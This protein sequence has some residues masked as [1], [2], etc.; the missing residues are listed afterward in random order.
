MFNQK[1]IMLAVTLVLVIIAST[2]CGSSNSSEGFS[3]V[4]PNNPAMVLYYAPWC[5]H[6]KD[7]MPD[8]AKLEKQCKK[9]NMNVDIKKINTDEEPEIAEEKEV[10]AF[11]DIRFEK[12][13]DSVQYEGERNVEGFMSFCKEQLKKN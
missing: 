3:N 7:I 4:E 13:E 12:G 2:L 10:N 11:P 9:N 1:I 5:P 6:C 8:W